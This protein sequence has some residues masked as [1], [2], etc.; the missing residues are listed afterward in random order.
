M[1]AI[2]GS[3]QHGLGLLRLDTGTAERKGELLATAYRQ[4]RVEQTS[5]GKNIHG[6]QSKIGLQGLVCRLGDDPWMADRV[7]AVLVHPR[8]QGRDIHIAYVLAFRS[9]RM[10]GHRAGATSKKGLA[11]FQ[12]WGEIERR[13]ET[14]DGF[15]RVHHFV[16]FTL[17]HFNHRVTPSE[18]GH[19]FGERGLIEFLDASVWHCIMCD[20][21]H[22][23][24]AGTAMVETSVELVD[25][26]G[27]GIVPIDKITVGDSSNRL[28]A[29][30][31]DVSN[32]V[33]TGP[34]FGNLMFLI[35]QPL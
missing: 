29:P 15:I 9:H 19:A 23:I 10:Q 2:L 16:P 13:Q 35:V 25:G 31:P 7:R 30:I 20:I 18:Q 6:R 22:G 32:A 8:V 5:R 3:G 34:L 27:Q 17:P 28:F 1:R 24:T 14:L 33:G 26:S 4:D 11:G 21:S 12:G